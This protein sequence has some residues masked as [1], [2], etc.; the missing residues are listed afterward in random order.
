MD[1]LIFYVNAQKRVTAELYVKEAISNKS[2]CASA[3]ASVSDS[4]S[5][6][7]CASVSDSVSACSCASS[8]A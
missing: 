5:A 2:A 6:C 4:V 8:C 3:C 7:S 1:S